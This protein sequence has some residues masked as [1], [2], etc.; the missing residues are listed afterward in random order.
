MHSNNMNKLKIL[1]LKRRKAMNIIVIKTT[2]KVECNELGA[3]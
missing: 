3:P 1:L 2:N